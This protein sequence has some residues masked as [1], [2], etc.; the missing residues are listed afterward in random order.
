MFSSDEEIKVHLVSHNIITDEEAGEK[1]YGW[2]EHLNVLLQMWHK[3][4]RSFVCI[5]R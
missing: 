3:N 2:P 4:G 5:R 1:K